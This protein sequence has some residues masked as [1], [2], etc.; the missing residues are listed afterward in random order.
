MKIFTIGHS[1]RSFENFVKILRYHKI[2]LLV[3]VRRFP[4]SKKYPHFNKEFLQE[5]LAKEKIDY[6]HYSELGGFRKEGYEKFSQSEDFQRAVEKLL[7]IIDTKNAAIMCAE[8]TPL[9][10]HRY[11]ISEYL[12]K[13]GEE[14]LHIID[15]K[16]IQ[17]HAELPKKK[18]KMICE[19][20]T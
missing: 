19:K 9:G 14:V 20:P 1:T 13:I 18:T 10:C 12:T 8:W 17:T 6:L 16:R 4:S 2:Q 5:H 15:E 3:D 7:V 11:Y